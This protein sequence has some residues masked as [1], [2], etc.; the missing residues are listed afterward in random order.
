MASYDDYVAS[1]N[2]WPISWAPTGWIACNGQLLPISEY[3]VLFALLGTIYGGNGQTTFGIPDM[4]G[5]IPL[6]FSQSPITGIYPIGSQGGNSSFMV[7]QANMPLQTHTHTAT[8]ALQLRAANAAGGA[9]TPGGLYLADS[10]GGDGYTDTPDTTMAS[11]V[12]QVS[13]G[14]ANAVPASAPVASLPPYLALTYIICNE[15]IYPPRN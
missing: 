15:G 7:T 8:G 5:R 1:I 3:N 12:L 10:P 6:G 2:L 4:Q 9:N 13:L 11:E 14:P